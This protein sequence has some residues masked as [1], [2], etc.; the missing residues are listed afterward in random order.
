MIV[1]ELSSK[2]ISRLLDGYDATVQIIDYTSFKR[3]GV[4]VY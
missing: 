2:G 1:D 3:Q 4:K